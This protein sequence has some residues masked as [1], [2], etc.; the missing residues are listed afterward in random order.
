MTLT[1][2]AFLDEFRRQ[3]VYRANGQRAPHKALTLMFAL[4]ELQRGRRLVPYAEGAPRI[5]ALLQEFGPPREIQRP[6]QPIWRLRARS[7]EHPEIWEVRFASGQIVPE[8]DNP[9][10]ALLRHEGAFGL[11]S[12][13]AHLFERDPGSL[14]EAATAIADSIVPES[15]RD[16]LL[17]ATIGE[18]RGAA[19][20]SAGPAMDL[21][22]HRR[23]VAMRWQRDPTFPRRVLDAYGHRCAV[24]TASPQL[25]GTRFGLEAAHIRW[26]QAAGPNSVQNGLC[27]CRMHHVALDRG[28]LTIDADRKITISPLVDQS[29]QSEQLFWTY[30]GRFLHAPAETMHRPHADYCEWHRTEVFKHEQPAA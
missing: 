2:Q 6:S 30:D 23:V 20:Q 18:S 8:T 7:V 26:I 5:A 27:L 9:P 21:Q 29:S 10:E 13:A 19:D 24:C 17:A 4:G 15:L 28:A 1:L 25:G 11:S 16:G 3:P 12:Q 22:P 14:L